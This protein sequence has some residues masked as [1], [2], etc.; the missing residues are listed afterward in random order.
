MQAIRTIFALLILAGLIAACED[1]DHRFYGPKSDYTSCLSGY[2]PPC[3]D[4]N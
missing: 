3:R 1:S 2:D 4:E